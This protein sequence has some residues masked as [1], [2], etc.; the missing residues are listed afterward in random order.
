MKKD[1]KEAP[2]TAIRRTSISS[3]AELVHYYSTDLEACQESEIFELSTKFAPKRKDAELLSAS[4]ERLRERGRAVRVAECGT[5]V[6]FAH[7]V[8]SGGVV[9]SHGRLC[10]ANFCRDR[11]C[12]LC[13]WRR[14]LKIYSQVSQIVSVIESKCQFLFLTLTIPNCSAEELSRTITKLMRGFD[15]LMK[16]KKVKTAVCGFFRALEVTRNAEQDTYHPH[17][18]VI[19][20]VSPK[21]FKGKDYIRQDEWLQM[22]RDSY[23][24]ETITQVDIR[25]ARGKSGS[26]DLASAVAE[27]AK[28]TVKSSDYLTSDESTTDRIVLTLAGALKGRRL[29]HFGG[30]FKE[31]AKKL[32]LDDPEDGDLIHIGEELHPAVAQLILT[33][34]WG[35]GLY[36]LEKRELFA[37][38]ASQLIDGASEGSMAYL[39][40][41]ALG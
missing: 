21:Y 40:L 3:S 33:Y 17:F 5:L 1:K 4:Y 9:D 34:R 18:H 29:V 25:R 39:D 16:L 35:I 31:I 36:K 6:Q 14:T 22:W 2:L 12:P 10:S 19:L 27:M 26:D 37:L 13:A 28:Y 30:I 24:D 23:G 15:R 7:A 32:K 20:A 41:D 8:D 11:L 38:D